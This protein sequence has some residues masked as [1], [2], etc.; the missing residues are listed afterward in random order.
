MDN[1]KKQST[2]FGV[3]K[4]CSSDEPLKSNGRMASL[5]PNNIQSADVFEIKRES[6]IKQEPVSVG[7]LVDV[8]VSTHCSAVHV[9]GFNERDAGYDFD[10]LSCDEAKAEVKNECDKKKEEKAKTSADN[11]E[12]AMDDQKDQSPSQNEEDL[13][14]V[15]NGTEADNTQQRGGSASGSTSK[16]HKCEFCEYSAQYKCLLNQHLLKHTG[17]KPHGCTFYSK[18][19]AN[20][21][22]LRAYMKVHV[23]ERA[24]EAGLNPSHR[25]KSPF[26]ST[27]SEL[28]VVEADNQLENPIEVKEEPRIKEEPQSVGELVDVPVPV[29]TRNN[30][31]VVP[32][33]G[34]DQSNGKYD[35]DSLDW[36]DAKIEVKEE[37]EVKKKKESKTND[38]LGGD[39]M[40]NQRDLQRPSR[41]DENVSTQPGSGHGAKN[42]KSCDKVSVP[43]TVLKKQ[44]C[45]VCEYSTDNKGHLNQPLLKHTGEKPHGCTLCP[46][47]FTTKQNLRSHMKAHVEEFLFHCSDCLQGF[48]GK[49]EKTEHESNCKIRRY[50]CHLCKESFGSLKANMVNHMR[51]HSGDKPFECEE[52]SK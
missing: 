25:S 1:E 13:Y 5:T 50:E 38:E 27:G 33:S 48:D 35:F 29:P 14:T 45:N 30:R 17:E 16:P 18:R 36:D 40:A 9:P 51:V 4:E 32:L 44:K 10:H 19:F 46:K 21:R 28:E 42:K 41:P 43:K 31:V 52:C 23:E 6:D 22:S 7:G 34:F 3:K 8:S 26:E 11:G 39:A 20:K 47:R 12:E 24:T 49:E 37:T 15:A 2:F